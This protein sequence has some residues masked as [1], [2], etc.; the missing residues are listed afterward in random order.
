MT[1]EEVKDGMD[2]FWWCKS[3]V[4][5]KKKK[6]QNSF[7][8]FAPTADTTANLCMSLSSDMMCN[9]GPFYYGVNFWALRLLPSHESSLS[10]Y[11]FWSQTLPFPNSENQLFFYLSLY[12]NAVEILLGQLVVMVHRVAAVACNPAFLARYVVC[13][14]DVWLHIFATTTSL[15]VLSK[16]TTSVNVTCCSFV[17]QKLGGKK[18][19]ISLIKEIIQKMVPPRQPK[20]KQKEKRRGS[21]AAE[22]G[23]DTNISSWKKLIG[24]R[25]NNGFRED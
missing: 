2:G 13:L 8:I 6:V 24:F 19:T 16:K 25:I 23:E 11:Q 18:P 15:N 5:V 22:S 3:M 4:H 17:S 14:G 20:E 1:H 10:L 12:W 21:K 9:I 7:S